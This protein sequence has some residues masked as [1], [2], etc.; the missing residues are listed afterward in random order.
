[1]ILGTEIYFETNLRPLKLGKTA[2]NFPNLRSL[3]KIILYRGNYTYKGS[4][5]KN[6]QL[7][8]LVSIISQLLS[9]GSSKLLCQQLHPII[10]QNVEDQILGSR[11][12]TKI[13]ISICPFLLRHPFYKELRCEFECE[14]EDKNLDLR[15]I[16]VWPQT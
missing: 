6:A 8:I 4:H 12:M 1:M 15:M 13:K 11:Y 10:L 5:R 9:I 16:K 7:H 2:G 3:I 14:F